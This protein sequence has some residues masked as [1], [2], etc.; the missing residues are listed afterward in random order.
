MLCCYGNTL[1]SNPVQLTNEDYIAQRSSNGYISLQCILGGVFV[2][3]CVGAG[4]Q[5]VV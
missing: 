3:V 2:C 1:K 5:C 4:M